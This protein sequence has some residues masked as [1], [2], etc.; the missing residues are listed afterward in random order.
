VYAL[1]FGFLLFGE[2]FP[3][4]AYLGMALVFLGI[5]LNLREK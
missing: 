3:I 2:T 4:P 1:I 5:L